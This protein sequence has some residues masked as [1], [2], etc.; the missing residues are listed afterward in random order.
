VLEE[1][2]KKGR[3]SKFVWKRD[4]FVRKRAYL[5][6]LLSWEEKRW[7]IRKALIMQSIASYVKSRGTGKK[8]ESTHHICKPAVS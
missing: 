2:V 4:P 6:L 5:L 1:K 8:N 7:Q 3:L